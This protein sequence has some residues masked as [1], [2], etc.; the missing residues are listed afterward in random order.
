M[1]NQHVPCTG[2]SSRKSGSLFELMKIMEFLGIFHNPTGLPGACSSL[3]CLVQG[4]AEEVQN[5]GGTERWHEPVA[6]PA[7]VHGDRLVGGFNTVSTW[8]KKACLGCQPPREIKLSHEH[9][10][11]HVRTPTRSNK[12]LLCHVLSLY[13]FNPHHV[14]D[15]CSGSILGYNSG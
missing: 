3:K 10:Q 6:D 11:T 12:H 14:K 2:V 15:G 1:E 7:S 13:C 5:T 9:V 8:W 4:D